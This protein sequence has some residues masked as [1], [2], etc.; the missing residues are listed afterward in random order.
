MAVKSIF[1]TSYTIPAVKA[2][3]VAFADLNAMKSY[4]FAKEQTLTIDTSLIQARKV[5]DNMGLTKIVYDAKLMAETMG[6]A[7]ADTLIA[8][9]KDSA[10][11]D[12]PNSYVPV[13]GHNVGYEGMVIRKYA[14]LL[15]LSGK[16]SDEFMFRYVKY[17]DEENMTMKEASAAAMEAVRGI[18][19]SGV[20][21][22]N[23]KYSET[24]DEFFSKKVKAKEKVGYTPGI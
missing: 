5:L 1:K 15:N 11:N 16:V 12:I 6:K 19:S 10:G 18:Y 3:A 21:V 2:P 23:H 14:D 24:L 7:A 9:S 4:E 17:I 22:I 13:V 20:K 8:L